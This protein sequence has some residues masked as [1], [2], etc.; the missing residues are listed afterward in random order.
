[1]R[2][3][4]H[5]EVDGVGVELGPVRIWLVPEVASGSVVG[6]HFWRVHFSFSEG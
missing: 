3:D 1:M 4:L 2:A 5:A 6:D